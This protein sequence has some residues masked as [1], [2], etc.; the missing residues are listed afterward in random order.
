MWNAAKLDHFYSTYGPEVAQFGTQG[1]VEE[2]PQGLIYPVQEAGTTLFF[3]CDW[4]TGTKIDHFYTA[5]PGEF[6]AKVAAGCQVD[7][8]PDIA[9]GVG[10]SRVDHFYTIDGAE[11]QQLLTSGVYQDEGIAGYVLP[12]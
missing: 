2:T 6:Q 4:N 10:S 3:R 8:E 9:Q 1:Y 7:S 11:R 12:N 5:D